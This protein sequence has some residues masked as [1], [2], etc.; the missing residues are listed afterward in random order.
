MKN[1]AKPSIIAKRWES[2]CIF[3]ILWYFSIT[4]MGL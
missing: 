1:V 2:R 3:L 4:N